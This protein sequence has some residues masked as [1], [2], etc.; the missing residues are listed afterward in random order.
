M[1]GR[2]DVCVIGAGAAG[3][4]CA[5]EAGRRGRRVVV[6][7][8]AEAPGEKIR[9][10]GGGRCN[11]T[12]RLANPLASPRQFLSANPDFCVSALKRFSA[13]DFIA[14]VDARGIAW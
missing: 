9:I 5:I 10:S 4:M 3:L 12:N 14:R 2:Y 11:F 7:D 6:I 8:H 13:A 1:S